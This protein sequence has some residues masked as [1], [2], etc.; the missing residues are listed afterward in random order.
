MIRD[1]RRKKVPTMISVPALKVLALVTLSIPFHLLC[2]QRSLDSRSRLHDSGYVRNE[3]KS[4]SNENL[5]AAMEIGSG[6]LEELR[7]AAENKDY[8]SAYQTWARYWEKKQ[9]PAY[10]TQN[11]RML[12]DTDMLMDY[13]DLRSYVR[14]SPEERDTILHRAAMLMDHRIPAWGN[15]VLEFG[16]RIDFNRDVGQ[17]G[18][19]GFHYWIWGRPLNAAFVITGEERYIAA[20]EDLF[21]Q[22]YDQRNN[23]TNSIPDLDVVYYELGLGVRNRIFIEF[24]SFP[25]PKRKWQTDEKMLKTMLGAAR[26]LYQLEHWEGYRSGN[27]QIHGSYMLTQIALTFPEF[28]ESQSWLE[29]GLRRLREHLEEDFFEDGGHSERAPRNYTQATYVAYR[30]LFYLLTQHKVDER[31]ADRIRERMSRTIDWWMTMLAPTGEVPAIND[32]HRGRFPVFLLQDAAAFYQKPEV[33]GILKQLFGLPVPSEKPLL[34]RFTSRNM[35]ASQF[36]VM[37]TDWTREALYMNIN[38]GPWSG[39]HTHE[40]VLDF[41]AYAYGRP[42]AVDAGIGLTYDDTLYVPWY[43]SS[44]AHNM[45]VVNDLNI[46]RR[47]TVGKEIR[48]HSSRTMDYFSGGHDGYSFKGIQHRRTI[49]FVKP[50]YWVFYDQ[51]TCSNGGDTLQWYLHTPL[52]LTKTKE[53]FTSRET[54]GFDLLL[55]NQDFRV[56]QGEGMAASTVDEIPGRTQKIQWIAFEQSSF[57][58]RPAEFMVVLAPFRERR[59][60]IRVCSK[61]PGYLLIERDGVFDELRFGIRSGKVPSDSDA[62]LLMIRREKNGERKFWIVNGTYLNEKGRT[63]WKSSSKSSTEGVLSEPKR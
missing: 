32:S 22:W 59:S 50:E 46:E 26:W 36:A 4:I 61:E 18:K 49:L 34:P 1:T 60:E 6:G 5:F 13:E 9:R 20:M 62:E 58:N 45:V 41:E 43:K 54:P 17:S 8:P 11:F 24:Y 44:R 7:I 57:A 48:W 52:N 53:G 15:V 33:Y 25:F 2:A 27:W 29:L 23:I 37:R 12:I 39:F 63:V 42:L 51:L 30:N 21:L 3:I 47:Q 56:R 19:Y 28:R 40:D 14:R 55:P 16:P 10:V 38:Y 31:L 35:A